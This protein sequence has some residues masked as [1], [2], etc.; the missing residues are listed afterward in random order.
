MLWRWRCFNSFQELEV[1]LQGDCEAEVP[2]GELESFNSF[3][4]LEGLL[5]HAGCLAKTVDGR[6]S[7]PFR[8]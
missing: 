6:V 8:N 3:P 5:P 1:L 2:E 4:V 7:I